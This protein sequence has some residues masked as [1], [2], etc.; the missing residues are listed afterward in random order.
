MVRDLRLYWYRGDWMALI[1]MFYLMLDLYSCI[2]VVGIVR[3]WTM[4]CVTA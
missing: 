4:L 3:Y 2:G 1:P